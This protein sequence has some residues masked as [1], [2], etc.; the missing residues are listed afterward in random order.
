MHTVYPIYM[1]MLQANINITTIN[2]SYKK[3]KIHN[4]KIF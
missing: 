4:T 1:F 3:K 2:L